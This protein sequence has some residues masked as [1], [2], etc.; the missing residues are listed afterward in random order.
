MSLELWLPDTAKWA[1]VCRLCKTRFT[2]REERAYE[3]HVVAC[4]NRNE[5]AL[6]ESSLSHRAPGL[7]VGDEEMEQWAR[8]TGKS[9]Y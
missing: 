6:A 2:K 8:R 4:G 5:A 7:T 1:Y 3:R 9:P